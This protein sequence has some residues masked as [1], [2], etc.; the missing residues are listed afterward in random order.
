MG[1]AKSRLLTTVAS[2]PRGAGV[3]S[4][5]VQCREHYLARTL[6]DV[7]GGPRWTSMHSLELLL[8]EGIGL[9]VADPYGVMRA[10]P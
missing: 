5:Y 8:V 9:D 2:R 7:C 3:T 4:I 10:H 6:P 1:T